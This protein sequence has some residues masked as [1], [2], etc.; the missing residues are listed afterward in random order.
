MSIHDRPSLAAI[1]RPGP[2]TRAQHK[3]IRL[4]VERL[5]DR[6][7][8]LAAAAQSPKVFARMLA[9]EQA[10]RVRARIDKIIGAWS[11]AGRPRK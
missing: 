1:I 9:R 8:A 4:E 3:A 7:D 11:R 10:E 2:K 5:D 6:L